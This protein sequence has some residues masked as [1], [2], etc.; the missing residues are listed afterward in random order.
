MTVFGIVPGWE[1]AFP[2]VSV[3]FAVG[4]A[5]VGG[6]LVYTG[7]SP[8][9]WAILLWRSEPISVMEAANTEGVVELEGRA[10]RADDRLESPFT[11]T[12]CLAYEYEIEAYQSSNTNNEW[13]T[14]HRGTDAVQFRLEDDTG[15]LV[16]DPTNA[17]LSFASGDSITVD[18]GSTATEPIASFLETIDVDPG[19]GTERS[20]GPIDVETGDLRRY[21][22]GRLEDGETVH[23]YG[24]VERNP[25]MSMRA[26]DFNAV[27]REATGSGRLLISDTDESATIRRYLTPG[28]KAIVG[29]LLVVVG[30]AG[31]LS[32]LSVAGV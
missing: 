32:N 25:P 21:S 8:L 24:S 13:D 15:G 2:S 23:V 29:V 18:R 3:E 20:L 31:L 9:Y 22:E 6:Y 16:V 11:H 12:P 1:L 10:V 28:T 30:G 26:G 7:I 14:L 17:S 19:S 4:I 5:L 27:V